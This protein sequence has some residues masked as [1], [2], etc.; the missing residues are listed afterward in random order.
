MVSKVNQTKGSRI[1]DVELGTAKKKAQINTSELLKKKFVDMDKEELSQLQSVVGAIIAR[2]EQ[3]EAYARKA[4][5]V[6]SERQID[7]NIR[8][9]GTMNDIVKNHEAYEDLGHQE[10]VDIA[11]DRILDAI[12]NEREEQDNEE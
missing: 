12:S 6:L 9:V 1:E 4:S 2:L 11:V 8:L 5:E 3:A 10:V 7:L